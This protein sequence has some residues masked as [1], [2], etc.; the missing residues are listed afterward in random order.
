MR[1]LAL[2]LLSLLITSIPL[3]SA[4]ADDIV[5]TAPA[6]MDDVS[7]TVGITGTVAPAG[8]ITYFFE[9]APFL[10]DPATV[11]W[12]P[13]T[14]PS[15]SAV[16]GGLLAEWDTSSLEDGA[17]ALRAHVYT[18]A[19]EVF[20]P[21]VRPLRVAN[22]G[23]NARPT[24][25][26]TAIP[27]PPRPTTVSDLPIPVG[28]QLDNFDEDA[29][30]FMEAAGMT[31]IKW[32]IPYTIGDASLLD[33]ARDRIDWSHERGFYAFLSIKGSKDELASV[34]GDEYF[35]LYADFLGQIAALSPDAIQVWNE[36]NLDR[37][38]PIGTIDPRAYTEMLRLSY[39]AIKAADPLVTVITG[40]PAPTGAEGAF[41]LDRVWNDDRYYLGMANAGAGD[42]SDCIGIHYNEGI[43]PPASQG[44]DPR[45]EYPTYYFQQMIQ[46]AAFP[47]RGQEKPFCFSELGYLSPEGYGTLPDG[48]AWGANTSEEEQGQWLREAVQI[49]ANT[50]APRVQLII[51]FNVNYTRFIDG[52]PQ[53]GFAIIR[54]DGTCP[55]CQQLA[56]LR[57]P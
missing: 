38:W 14:L 45:G 26:P 7:G 53:G 49:A 16:T 55:A 13:I 51:V 21:L 3:V 42:Y 52:D 10:S 31:W 4:Q 9:V 24:T 32:Q 12:T 50:T 2:L 35:P 54:P 44:G 40:A 23:S 15:N 56:T 47:F 1:K 5:I 17:Y 30:A 27:R 28:G 22:T 11:A 43:L 36:M 34:G 39:T 41:G 8:L 6:P 25:P 37:E 20:S 29:A 33:V 46:R 18:A 48:F 57:T 19:G